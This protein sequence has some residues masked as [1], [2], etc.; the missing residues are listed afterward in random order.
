MASSVGTTTS[1]GARMTVRQ[2]DDMTATSISESIARKTYR[3]RVV[4]EVKVQKLR[5][6]VYKMVSGWVPAEKIRLLQEYGAFDGKTNEEYVNKRLVE[7]LIIHMREEDLEILLKDLQV[8]ERQ[9][10]KDVS[11]IR[12]AQKI[13][14]QKTRRQFST[15]SFGTLFESIK[16]LEDPEKI[17]RILRKQDK[18]FKIPRYISKTYIQL[19]KELFDIIKGIY[20]RVQLSSLAAEMGI[21]I[22]EGSDFQTVSTHI[23]NKTL[24]Y[25]DLIVGRSKKSF[26]GAILDPEPYNELL[27]YTSFAYVTGKRGISPSEVKALRDSAKI[28]KAK[29]QE[30]F[31]IKRF[32]QK[33]KITKPS[34]WGAAILKRLHSTSLG[35]MK[36]VDELYSQDPDLFDEVAATYG[37][38]KRDF[39]YGDNFDLKGYKDAVAKQLSMQARRKTRLER[40]AAGL[41]A[42]GKDS[43]ELRTEISAITAIQA[44]AG[45]SLAGSI[46][47]MGEKTPIIDL[48]Q[49]FNVTDIVAA[50]PVFVV[51][52]S[53]KAIAEKNN[54]RLNERYQERDDMDVYSGKER[55][56]YQKERKL[57]TFKE[58]VDL[59]KQQRNQ[60]AGIKTG[61]AATDPRLEDPS[62][63][64]KEISE[65]DMTSSPA[66]T[67][68]SLLLDLNK[69]IQMKKIKGALALRVFDQTDMLKERYSKDK[70]I[71][72]K[73]KNNFFASGSTIFSKGVVGLEIDVLKKEPV[74]PVYVVNKSL[75]T[76]AGRILLGIVSLL[77]KVLDIFMPGM[78][79]LA[80]NTISKMA[81]GED[82]TDFV[83]LA[84]SL[85][86]F[87]KGGKAK[88]TSSGKKLL[89]D[90]SRKTKADYI[91]KFAR[92]TVSSASSNTTQFIAGDSQTSK[93]N[94]EKVSIDWNKKSF[95]VQ[96]VAKVGKSALQQAGISSVSKLKDSSAPLQV[97]TINNSLAE[98]VDVGGVK[99]SMINL[100]FELGTRLQNIENL[101]SIGN[102]QRNAV[103]STNAAI[104]KNISKSQGG[105]SQNP[106]LSGGFPSSLNGI[107]QGE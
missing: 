88:A 14:A 99:T 83:N 45:K 90:F 29:V 84:F 95:E 78:G 89:S 9:I 38:T 47:S 34:T 79:T 74:T 18:E 49:K 91:P 51:N 105:T 43:S 17:Q 64:S 75:P 61:T 97:V 76:D 86:G 87:S 5:E 15:A 62:K 81:E 30:T 101:L 66:G 20:N 63:S 10:S 102:T 59:L 65:S 77:G 31:K 19:K 56:L 23:I 8:E 7:T 52:N 28:A 26:A 60:L 103:I 96:P 58:K 53:L 48:S 2:F 98:L 82:P 80:A 92:G 12:K 72:D 13:A 104:A 36:K 55:R 39:G 1:L 21:S 41:E 54:E 32:G 69:P 42:K 37:I 40:K 11:N 107:L 3:R 85:A 70:R 94:E 44:S 33:G 46:F 27:Q 22:E 57:S 16:D 25:V 50:V 68:D 35:A 4:S 106:F 100:V 93:P 71:S 73:N 67:L 24:L 6:Y